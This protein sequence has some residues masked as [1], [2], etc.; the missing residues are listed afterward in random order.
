MR[1]LESRKHGA[2]MIGRNEWLKRANRTARRGYMLVESIG[3]G[4]RESMCT[5]IFSEI[6]VTMNSVREGFY[7]Q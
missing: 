1:T 4:R 7:Q 2:K 6:M 3:V 5:C